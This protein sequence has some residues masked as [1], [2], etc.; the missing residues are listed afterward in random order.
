[1]KNLNKSKPSDRKST[2]PMTPEFERGN[3]VPQGL[4]NVETGGGNIVTGKGGNIIAG[5]GGN[6]ANAGGTIIINQPPPLKPAKPEPSWIKGLKLAI[7]VAAAF[8]A[9]I[10]AVLNLPYPARLATTTSEKPT[11]ETIK[12]EHTAISQWLL[13]QQTR[14]LN[15][16]AIQL[17]ELR[18][19]Y[20]HFTNL[21]SSSDIQLAAQAMANLKKK[22]QDFDV[23]VAERDKSEQRGR[24]V[25]AMNQ[26]ALNAKAQIFAP[27]SFRSAL[28]KKDEAGKKFAVGDF[29]QAEALYNT[30]VTDFQIARKR[31]EGLLVETNRLLL[32]FHLSK[33]LSVGEL[34]QESRALAISKVAI[35]FE[36]EYEKQVAQSIL[37]EWHKK[38]EVEKIL[39]DSDGQFCELSMPLDREYLVLLLKAANP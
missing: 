22:M 1:M 10:A 25:Q 38:S 32:Q 13:Q 24:E 37:D 14:D 35:I 30:A 18:R 4:H 27:K 3:G 20:Q 19:D 9:L 26:E 29:V 7:S 16:I 17:E 36:K 28:T 2:Q 12:I 39:S 31:S 6:I 21:L 15:G 5:K 11:K 8:V 33:G 23:R 34:K